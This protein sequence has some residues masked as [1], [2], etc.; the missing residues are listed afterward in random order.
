DGRRVHV[1]ERDLK[2]PQR[3]M[4]EL[5]QAGG[6]LKLAQLGLEDCL[7]EIDAQES[8]SLAIY[9]DGKHGTLYYP[10]STKFP[11]EP[12]G[13]FL[14]NGRLVQRLRKKAISLA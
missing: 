2:E 5:M 10:S 7:K 11:Y 8:K 12:Q 3:F 6:R 1:I 4:G 13:R 9:K 14:R